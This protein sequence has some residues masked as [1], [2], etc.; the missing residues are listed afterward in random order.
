MIRYERVTLI[1]KFFAGP[2][3][4]R[5]CSVLLI[6]GMI[7]RYLGHALS[8]PHES[9]HI[10]IEEWFTRLDGLTTQPQI[11]DCICMA[12]TPTTCASAP[13]AGALDD[14]QAALSVACQLILKHKPGARV[15]DFSSRRAWVE[16]LYDYADEIKAKGG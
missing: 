16:D 14:E 12:T 5:F 15:M 2:Q 3:Q 9:W 13:A 4:L 8:A 1:D 6:N 7:C 10:A 11:E